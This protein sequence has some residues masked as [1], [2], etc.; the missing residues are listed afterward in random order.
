MKRCN[1]QSERQLRIDCFIREGKFPSVPFLSVELESSK[2]TIKRDVEFMRDRLNLPIAYDRQRC[3]Y[4]YSEKCTPIPVYYLTQTEM[5]ELRRVCDFMEDMCD[6]KAGT[7]FR[8][9]LT[10]FAE[11]AA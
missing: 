7:V 8:K 10:R 5:E 3:G 6:S 11:L 1:T 9:L 2:R 4:Y